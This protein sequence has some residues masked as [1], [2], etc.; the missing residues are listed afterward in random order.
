MPWIPLS[1]F[2]FGGRFARK[3]MMKQLHQGTA[4]ETKYFLQLSSWAVPEN[5]G[6]WERRNPMESHAVQAYVT[7][8]AGC[9]SS[10]IV[11][12]SNQNLIIW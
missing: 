8:K 3:T 5:I 10:C 11:V 12:G 6:S 4:T 9:G 7:D 1:L 2:V